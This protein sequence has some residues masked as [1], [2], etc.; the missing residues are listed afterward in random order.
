M[1]TKGKLSLYFQSNRARQQALV[2]RNPSERM[3]MIGAPPHYSALNPDRQGGDTVVR[4]TLRL[5][6]IFDAADAGSVP[7]S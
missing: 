4:T 3:K 5:W 7:R 1:T 2:G 6:V